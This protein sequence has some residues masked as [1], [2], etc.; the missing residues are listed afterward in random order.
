[1]GKSKYAPALF[2]VIDTGKS[3]KTSGKLA[4]PKWW[5]SKQDAP[6]IEVEKPESAID[7]SEEMPTE[8]QP[9]STLETELSEIVTPEQP[10]P[11]VSETSPTAPPDE[12]TSPMERPIIT[13]DSGRLEISLNPV[14]SFITVCVLVLALVASYQFGKMAAPIE[15]GYESV[16]TAD[17]STGGL[18]DVIN[19]RPNADVLNLGS[20]N[21]S[22]NQ[23]AGGQNHVRANNKSSEGTSTGTD[24]DTR[25]PGKI[26]VVI[27]SFKPEHYENAVHAQTWLA[28]N[29]NVMTSLEKKGD[30]W[31][32]ISTK[33]FDRKKDAEP[34]VNGIKVLGKEYK[35]TFGGKVLHDF[36]GP[37]TITQSEN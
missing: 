32:L 3:E 24:D 31:V 1:V 27:E 20:K 8:V 30:R 37:Y 6:Q 12:E 23:V 7:S 11:V 2:E 18:D 22:S 13:L 15:S 36:R 33:G 5:K 35:Q 16:Q 14:S 17:T 28:E 26:Y 21:N 4:L 9:S 34:F 25:I 29:K 10:D 19:Q